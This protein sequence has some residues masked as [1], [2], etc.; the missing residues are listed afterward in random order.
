MNKIKKIIVFILKKIA[1]F[2]YHSDPSIYYKE[3]LEELIFKLYTEE[4]L[5]ECY[6]EFKKY[7]SEAIFL[8]NT[9]IREYSIKK[10]IENDKKNE[11]FY[12][13]FGV[14][15]GESINYFSKLIK[16][17][18]IYGFDSFEGLIEDWKGTFNG[19]KGTFNL[20]GNMPKVSD[21][22]ILVKGAI[23]N[24]LLNFLKEKPNIKINF[25]H[26]DVDTY[27]ST[28]FILKTIKPFLT[29]KC[30]ISFDE[31]YNFIGWKSGEYKALKESFKE[32]EIKF[33]AFSKNGARA[34]IEIQ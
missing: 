13:E 33:L 3:S 2:R 14:Y 10:A 7:F 23:Q 34:V 24:T 12:L 9:N 29:D 16:N 4:A 6:E 15:K 27:E 26:M 17:N 28:N 1:F 25:V 8:D 18:K 22:V 31:I 5:K 20:H 30:I 19:P 32:S 21:N 11:F